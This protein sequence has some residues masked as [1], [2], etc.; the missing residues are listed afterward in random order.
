MVNIAACLKYDQL[1]GCN[2]VKEFLKTIKSLIKLLFYLVNNTCILVI[3][4]SLLEGRSMRRRMRLMRERPEAQK[5]ITVHVQT[6]ETSSGK[7]HNHLHNLIKHDIDI[8]I[9]LKKE[10]ATSL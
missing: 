10:N 6:S 3:S 4:S 7:A 2:G 1:F 9:E 5:Q 8:Y